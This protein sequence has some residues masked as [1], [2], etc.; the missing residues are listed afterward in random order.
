[1]RSVAY[2]RGDNVQ[3]IVTLSATAVCY[4]LKVGGDD[5]ER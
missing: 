2:W 4:F 5:Y 1:M 3:N